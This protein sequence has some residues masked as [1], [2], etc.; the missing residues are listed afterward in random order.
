MVIDARCLRRLTTA[1]RRLNWT[2]TASAVR[3]LTTDANAV[4][5]LIHLKTMLVILTT[6]EER[7]GCAPWDEA[8]LLQR[9]LPDDTLSIVMSAAEKG[10][11]G[12]GAA[13]LPNFKTTYYA[14][15]IADKAKPHLIAARS[16]PWQTFDRSVLSDTRRG[17]G[18]RDAGT[19]SD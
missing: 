19:S 12:G 10:R 6:E 16:V 13:Q 11:T 5:K 7:N 4:I 9:R 14:A 2:G 1:A 17:H 8:K 18:M 3:L 15:Q